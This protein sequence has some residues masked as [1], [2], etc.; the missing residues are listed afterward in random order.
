MDAF[1][2]FQAMSFLVVA[3]IIIG[4][5]VLV[6]FFNLTLQKAMN[7]VS[8]KN[9]A[10]NPAGLI[11]LNFIPLCGLNNIWTVIYGILACTSI[12]KDA[13]QKIAPLAL[14][15]AYPIVGA[16]AYAIAIFTNIMM[17]EGKMSESEAAPVFIVMGVLSLATMILWIIFWVQLNN[18]KNKLIAM[19]G[20]ASKKSSDEI[21][22]ASF[23]DAN[24]T[25]SNKSGKDESEKIASL[26]KYKEL[27]DQGIISQEE[28]DQKK[29]ELL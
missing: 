22:D 7:A 29:R 21:L 10:V 25:G 4:A 20:T 6:I 26:K 13:Q 11:W 9:R 16:I 19:G 17:Q 23:S 24:D 18:A 3:L 2:P 27:L 5:I 15:I 1:G 14:A 12:N 8:E 28:F